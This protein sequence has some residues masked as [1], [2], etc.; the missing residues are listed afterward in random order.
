MKYMSKYNIINISVLKDCLQKYVLKV[1]RVSARPILL[2]WF[3][4]TS[5]D[6]PKSEKVM[7]A[8]A[9]AYVILPI[10]LI[11]T[12]RLPLIGWIDE[13]VSLTV[14]YQKVCKYITPEI[15]WKTD[16]LLDRWFPEYVSYVEMV[17]RNDK[18]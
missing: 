17:D 10:D 6:T 7:L 5:S 4:M 16:D 8:S 13:V 15:E 2:L 18:N 3:V 11:S 12:K 1:G 9:I 14:A